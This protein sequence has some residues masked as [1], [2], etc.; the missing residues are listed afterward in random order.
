MESD[1]GS[2]RLGRHGFPYKCHDLNG[3]KAYSRMIEHVDQPEHV[4]PA[5][6]SKGAVVLERD[7]L[8]F[9]VLSKV[10]SFNVYGGS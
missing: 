5:I 8:Q 4:L 3:Y 6:L 9:S 7:H 10:G 1:T 2:H